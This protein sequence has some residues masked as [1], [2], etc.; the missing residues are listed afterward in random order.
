MANRRRHL[1]LVPE[2]FRR[3]RDHRRAV[4]LAAAFEAHEVL[5]ADHLQTPE[6]VHVIV[7]SILARRLARLAA[8]HVDVVQIL[9]R[10]DERAHVAGLLPGH[11][12]EVAHHADA[13]VLR[14]S[15][16]GSMLVVL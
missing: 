14:L 4:S 7:A 13:G 2:Q 11:V 16:I 15:L 12:P 6:S 5:V 9:A 10:G 1:P 3:G 8:G